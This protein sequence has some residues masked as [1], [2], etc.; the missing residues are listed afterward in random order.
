VT[1]TAKADS[2]SWRVGWALGAQSAGGLAG[3]DDRCGRGAG[4]PGRSA[5]SRCS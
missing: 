4:A 5:W 3:A 1:V 2:L